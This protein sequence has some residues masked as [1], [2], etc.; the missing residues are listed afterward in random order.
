MMD[1]CTSFSISVSPLFHKITSLFESLVNQVKKKKILS[2]NNL[3]VLFS[4]KTLI[5]HWLRCYSQHVP[6][7][8]VNK[9]NIK[10]KTYMM[11][12]NIFQNNT[13]RY[14]FFHIQRSKFDICVER[15]GFIKHYYAL[16]YGFSVHNE[17]E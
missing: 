7:I 16:I 10:K 6:M 4:I 17:A 3:T 11:G 15:K 8:K 1:N 14:I 9:T 5:T 12:E 13:E 2:I